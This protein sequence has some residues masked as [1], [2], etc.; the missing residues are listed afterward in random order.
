MRSLSPRH[1]VGETQATPGHRVWP[2]LEPG[3]DV[4]SGEK[5]ALAGHSEVLAAPPS[6]IPLSCVLSRVSAVTL[7]H[8]SL[9]GSHL[10]STAE[11]RNGQILD[12][13]VR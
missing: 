11:K 13:S 6:G 2:E 4:L 7:S 8:L 9:S 5:P 1:A 10:G 3:V 12:G